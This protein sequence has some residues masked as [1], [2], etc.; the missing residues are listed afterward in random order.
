MI[1]SK[2]SITQKQKF[3]SWF[4]LNYS[5]STFVPVDGW[6]ALDY[7]KNNHIQP[8]TKCGVGIIVW[9]W[10]KFS[11]RRI[12]L[13]EIGQFGQPDYI[14]CASGLYAHLLKYGLFLQ[15][16]V[17][18]RFICHYCSVTLGCIWLNCSAKLLFTITLEISCL[19]HSYS[20]GN[21]KLSALFPLIG[22]HYINWPQLLRPPF[23]S[24]CFYYC[25]SKIAIENFCFISVTFDAKIL[26]TILVQSNILV[27]ICLILTI[28]TYPFW[29]VQIVYNKPESPWQLR[30]A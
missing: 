16:P 19:R 23:V 14:I 30:W 25:N 4:Q 1:E 18:V 3:V 9:A 12:S 10:G 20:N 28:S 21:I 15:S 13:S 7:L 24:E 27:Y 11:I 29:P 26:Y 8:Q 17:Y 22:W 6:R 2:L 5:Y